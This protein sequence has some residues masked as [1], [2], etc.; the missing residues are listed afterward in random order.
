[1]TDAVLSIQPQGVAV[2]SNPPP[3]PSTPF[4]VS[5]E[6]A[7]G[8]D[9]S[10]QPIPPIRDVVRG[11][12]DTTLV[13][14]I[15]VSDPVV[16]STA[17]IRFLSASGAIKDTASVRVPAA[18]AAFSLDLVAAQVAAIVKPD[19]LPDAQPVYVRR[20]AR[21]VSID[22]T[23]VD[24]AAL[25]LAVVPITVAANGWTQRGL[26][27]LFNLPTASTAAQ[28]AS[29]PLPTELT[30]LAWAP[31]HLAIDGQFVAY[32]VEGSGDAWLWS[33]TGPTGAIGVVIDNL[34]DPVGLI[35]IALPPLPATMPPAKTT[36][37]PAPIDATEREIVDNPGIYTEDPGAFCKPFSNPERV[38]GERSFSVIY[39]AEQPVVSPEASVR[40]V[41]QP[42]LD[43]ELPAAVRDAVL[44][45]VD[46]RPSV[47]R[48]IAASLRLA[49][50]AAVRT[51]RTAAAAAITAIRTPVVD[52]FVTRDVLPAGLLDEIQR[53]DR[54][55]HVVDA[56][57][58][59]QWDSDASRYQAVTVARGHILEF[60]LRWR[61]NGYS[62]GTVAKTLTLAARQVKRIQKIEWRRIERSRR[63]ERTQLVDRV[64]DA[65][66]RD[67]QYDDGVEAT[68]SEWSRGESESSSAAGAGGFGFATA[69]FVIGGGG[70]GSSAS[71]SSSQQGGRR[72]TASEEQRLRDTIRRYGDSLRRLDSVVVNEV[73][74]EE[75]VTGTSEII[76]NPNFGHA[77]TLIY[78]QILRHLK[79]E[80]AFAGVRECLFVPFALKSFTVARAFRWRDLIR[81][82]LLDRRFEQA[83]RYLKDVLTGF[84]G[85]EIP[86]GPRSQQ[87][88]RY[89]S[90]SLYLNLAVAR[91]RD[92]DAG[93][94]DAAAWAVLNPFIA[95]PAGGIFARLHE[96][97]EAQRDRDFQEQ[98]APGIA[99][100]WVNT[101]RVFA[102]GTQ[103]NAD[104]TLASRY[105][106]NGS[107]RVDFAAPVNTLLTRDMLASIRVVATHNLPPNS[108]A[109]LTRLTITY[110]TDHFQRP[111]TASS[112][113]G[114]L[115]S[116]QTGVRDP[117][118]TVFSLPDTWE[119]QNVRAEMV[120]A[121]NDLVGHLNEHAE[122]Y[123][124]VIWWN[125]DRDR[126]FML[127][128]GFEVP[129]GNGRS[130]G[131][132]IER[133]PIAI[134]GNSLVFRVSAGAFLG[135]GEL[136]EPIKLYNY[137]A[138]HQPVADPMLISLPTDGLY[139]QTI[140]DECEALE[141]HYGSTDW[142]LSDKEPEI[143]DIDAGLL[144]T[145]RADPQ[146][147][148]PTPFPQT[149]INLQ[150]APE[151]P[152]PSGLAGVL[153]AVTNPNAFRDM[154]G[155]AGTQANAAAAL[156]AAAALATNFGNQA[157]ALKLAQ[158]AKAAQDTGTADRRLA[159][160]QRAAEKQLVTPGQAQGHADKILEELHAPT[161]TPPHENR[162]ISDAIKA[163]SGRPGST[164]EA[165]TPDGQARVVLASLPGAITQ[166]C[167][168][169]D[170]GGR[171]RTL[172][173]VSDAV[174]DA[175]I[176][177]QSFWLKTSGSLFLESDS[178]QFGHLL[179]YWLSERKDIGAANMLALGQAAI[180]PATAYLRLLNPNTEPQANIDADKATI[181]AALIALVPEP[182]TPTDLRSRIEDALQ[183]A[184]D[185][186]LESGTW[187][188][189]SAA[190]VNSC[191]R[192][193]EFNLNLE[194]LTGGT[195]QLLTLS[196]NGRHWEYVKG[197]HERTFGCV[198]ADGTFDSRCI[199]S[200]T[201]Q[202]FAPAD[203]VIARGDII[204]QD[205]RGDLANPLF[206][207]NV[208][209]FRR[210]Q[211][212]EGDM[213][214]DIV[215]DVQSGYAET[216]GGNVGDSSKRRRYPR[217]P[218]GTLVVDRSQN[219]VQQ[220]T[221]GL[222]PNLPSAG[223]AYG[224]LQDFS[225]RR[226]FA[227][228]GLVEECR[229]VS[230]PNR[231]PET[232]VA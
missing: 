57:H 31:I 102:G 94:F 65:V 118:A 135:L 160:V 96:L 27:K 133:D 90:G 143:G 119:Q 226:L 191:V 42:I 200:A 80:T 91:P 117:G 124:K 131:S 11:F 165:T 59:V 227:V 229:I 113:T 5:F 64:S 217:N 134:V 74:Q 107:V 78:Y 207:A 195:E 138:T 120:R 194:G 23:T 3:P 100:S 154:A 86:P 83:L 110:Q 30:D 84:V 68:L 163:A 185:S 92:T 167:G 67:R 188:N 173:E 211:S 209:K 70:G 206:P 21:F 20:D 75:E 184:R 81:R 62:L 157:A 222:I 47:I 147:T 61:S 32:F 97:A 77:L 114:D 220:A 164:I 166:R 12:L 10:G 66:T 54:G 181:A 88:I 40:T 152:G 190:F 22:G 232:N 34:K 35:R 145:R 18:G 7:L 104:L 122:H 101:I 60:R 170:L 103:L 204:V 73:T 140:M 159:S 205:R 9:E 45:E 25:N 19:P 168:F 129:G 33:L 228:L 208:W 216:I 2:P 219:F 136:D 71:S 87:R 132:V 36:G 176:D 79:V 108:V 112:G 128:D 149:L 95:V 63:E 51:D 16:G 214:G 141:E 116:P 142:V 89:V 49:P 148:T 156:Q 218:D 76:R 221:N 192:T 37:T 41:T 210:S 230:E 171:W 50:A 115:V 231:P 153:N 26:A 127:V 44:T 139:A 151:A 55:R 161:T 199:K 72:T 201:Y 46:T 1:M 183:K 213:H 180:D 58:P 155:L 123:H 146:P 203:R 186:R 223:S 98:H 144:G 179:R 106:Y 126:I 56:Q 43:F 8:N 109:N 28:P 177:E 52:A 196:P 175:A 13:G 99:A 29:G 4:E 193:A 82:G 38:L 198:R 215:V 172:T 174:V 15:A 53:T 14:S 150:N 69:G 202:A 121:V 212:N 6:R 85:S 169:E 197:A 93:A 17:E 130:I 187:P 189:W 111:F 182:T 162:E 225:T 48:R 158:T 137:Y 125:M 24:F 39:R 178:A 224:P 105:Q